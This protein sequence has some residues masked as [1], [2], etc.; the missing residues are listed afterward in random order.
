MDVPLYKTQEGETPLVVISVHE[1]GHIPVEL[2][3]RNGKPLGINDPAD[4]DRHIAVD[5]GAGEVTTLLAQATNAHVFR[6]THSRLV[7]D[8]NRFQGELECIA[9]RADGTDIP[10]SKGLSDEQRSDRLARFYFPVLNRM[11][12]FVA[13]L[14][15]QHGCEPFVISMHSYA[16]TQRENPTPKSEDICVFGYPEFGT[17]PKLEKFVRQL[18]A[19]NPELTIGNNRPFSAKTPALQTADDDYRMACPVTY[20]NVIERNNVFNHFCLEICQDL[21]Q[22]EDAQR[23][24]A[25]KVVRALEGLCVLPPSPLDPDRAAPMEFA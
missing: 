20:Y 18:R 24:M 22:T 21:L 4:L 16:R 8:V 12:E 3:D 1:R 7:A 11:K 19:D 25:A 14:A 17:S 5:L 10:L 15:R 13:D 23:T 6:V 9:P 2:H